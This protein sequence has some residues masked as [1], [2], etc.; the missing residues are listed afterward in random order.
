MSIS[1]KTNRKLITA[2]KCLIFLCLA[3]MLLARYTKIMMNKRELFCSATLKEYADNSIEVLFLGG[4][5]MVYA[6]QPMILWEQYGITSYNMATSATTIPGNYWSA[7]IAFETQ[8]PKVVMLDCTLSQMETK[9]F[10]ELPRIHAAIDA[11]WPSMA[12]YQAINDLVEDP[13]KRFEF[14]WTPYIYHTRWKELS[15]TDFVKISD[16]G[17]GGAWLV[18]R[19]ENL[20]GMVSQYSKENMQDVPPISLEYIEKLMLLCDK[21]DSEL[22]LTV[23]PIPMGTDYQPIYNTLEKWAE[24]KGIPFINGYDDPEFWQLDYGTDFADVA[25]MN[26]HGVKKSSAYIGDYLME[27]YNLGLHDDEQT[28]TFWNERLEEYTH[29]KDS[30]WTYPLLAYGNA[31]TFG[32]DGNQGQFYGGI[33]SSDRLIDPSGIYTWT[34]GLRSDFYFYIDEPADASLLVNLQAV[35][36]TIGKTTRS[37]DIYINDTYISS[38]EVEAAMSP[39]AFSVDIN[40]DLWVTSGEQKLTFKY[41]DIDDATFGAMLPKYTLGLKEIYLERK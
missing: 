33:G 22:V 35:Q 26:I 10:G 41:S 8:K 40:K 23:L 13:D 36:S 28:C 6:A 30:V 14:Y 11:L 12:A 1:D 19:I 18:E 34:T 16:Y 32:I 21:N 5:Q 4:S 17:S 9:T 2:I 27:H 3:S 38:M 20:D 24:E 25:H 7:R 15:E 29:F 39:S 37:V 31:I